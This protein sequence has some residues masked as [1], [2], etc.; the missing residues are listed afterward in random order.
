MDSHCRPGVVRLRGLKRGFEGSL[1]LIGTLYGY[2]EDLFIAR[3]RWVSIA[4]AIRA[5]LMGYEYLDGPLPA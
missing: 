5:I 2:A 3:H 4:A 1:E